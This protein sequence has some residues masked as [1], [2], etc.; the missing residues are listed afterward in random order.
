MATATYTIC[1]STHVGLKRKCNEDRF[2]L[3]QLGDGSIL[4]AVADGLGGNCTGDAAAEIVRNALSAIREVP[5]RK[6]ELHL[7]ELARNIDRVVL[8]RAGEIP[9]L[10]EMGATLVG[11]LVRNGAA[12]WVHVGDSRMYLFRKERLLQVT[13]DQT[14]ARFLVAEGEIAPEQVPTHYSRHA[15]DQC[16]GCGYCEPETGCVTLWPDDIVILATD[17]LH[18]EIEPQRIVA[19]LSA[20]TGIEAR[21]DALVEAALASGGKD[22]ITVVVAG[23]NRG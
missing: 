19:E 18:K 10:K 15:M 17:G 9:E 3:R 23:K 13:K 8:R 4:M 1:A 11:V 22:N 21:T 16:V 20:R 12:H 6:E 7:C 5:E 14:L 2:V